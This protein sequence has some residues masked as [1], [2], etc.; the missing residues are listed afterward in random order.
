MSQSFTLH[1]Q[2]FPPGSADRL[3]VLVTGSAG[4]IGR[5][6][7]EHGTSTYAL[8][9]MIRPGKR[10][11]LGPKHAALGEVVEADLSDLPR[12]KDAC[13]GIDTVIHLAGDPSPNATWDSL[14]PANIVGTY[15]VMAAAKS[16]GVRLVIY[17]SSIHAVGGFGPTRQ[18]H[19]AEPPNP[20]DLYGV[21]KCFGEALGRYLAEQEG[22]SVIALRIGAFQP[23]S[24]LENKDAANIADSWISP[25]DMNQMLD[26]CIAARHVRWGVFNVL[27]NNAF[28]RLDISDAREILGYAPVDDAFTIVPGLAAYD[29]A[30]KLMKHDLTDGFAK[31]GMRQDV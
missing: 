31:S 29:F 10:D 28:N 4:N 21:S 5:A 12:L 22:M 2:P 13:R 3:S 24:A 18:S 27:S 8:R 19:T 7:C 30:G 9:L 11:E 17:A 16:A 26:R 6:F 14:L 1:S 20:G 23:A 15:N 25:R